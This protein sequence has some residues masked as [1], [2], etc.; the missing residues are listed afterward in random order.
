[1]DAVLQL[2]ELEISTQG[3]TDVDAPDDSGLSLL[4]GCDDSTVSL[5]TCG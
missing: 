4:A 1:M 2:Q 3:H 5:L